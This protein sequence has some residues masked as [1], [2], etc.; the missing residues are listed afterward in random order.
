VTGEP[1]WLLDSAI[2]AVHR[3]LIAEHGGAEGLRDAGLL[4]SALSRPQ[5][6]FAYS[7]PPPSL[8]ALAAGY[9]YGLVKNHPF[10]DGNKRI[11]L[12]AAL[13]FLELNG[14]RLEA[15]KVEIYDRMIRLA[16]G[17]LGE[18]DFASWLEAHCR[19]SGR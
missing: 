15:S 10:V 7:D 19:E 12:T 6:L 16:G 4:A 8:P 1:E 14:L 9:A 18:G 3:I 2:L 11:A 13:T 17:D 5:N